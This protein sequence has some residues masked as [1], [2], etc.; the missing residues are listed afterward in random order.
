MALLSAE[1]LQK[2]SP[3]AFLALNFVRANWL[4]LLV[5]FY[6]VRAIRRRYFHP[7]SG[8]PGPFLGSITSWYSVY[9]FF[10]KNYNMHLTEVELHKKYGPVFRLKPDLLLCNDPKVLPKLFHKN[11]D[12]AAFI[13]IEIA[14]F[15]D[16][17]LTAR[18]S[19]L[20]VRLKKRIA[21]AYSMTNIRRMESDIDILVLELIKQLDTRFAT[22]GKACDFALWAQYFA[23]DVVADVAFG[24]PLGFIE[25]GSDV[26]Q[27]VENFHRSLPAAGVMVRAHWLADLLVKIPGFTYLMPKSGD[28]VGVGALMTFRDKLIKER[29]KEG[30][31]GKK[32]DLLYHFLNAK[33]ADGTPMTFKEIGDECY[34][35]LVAGSDTTAATIRYLIRNLIKPGNEAMLEKLHAELSQANL[36]R[37]VPS[38]DELVKLPYLGAAL[39]EA[40]RLNGLGMFIPRAISEPGLEVCGKFVPPGAGHAIAM[41]PWVVARSKEVYGEDAEVFNPERWLGSEEEK[42]NLLRYDFGWGYGNRT[43]LGKSIAMLEMTKVVACLLLGFDMRLMKE[44]EGVE[45]PNQLKNLSVW[46]EKGMWV[47]LKRKE[48]IE[49]MMFGQTEKVKA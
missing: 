22:T 47:E 39:Y 36:T 35:I 13:D 3:Y 31:S 25:A 37:P 1:N 2:A 18:S 4:Y 17:V 10:S 12:K 7:L 33:N 6:V 5:G 26:G 40:M 15:G 11:A 28:T 46:V 20:H 24:K 44:D 45:Y 43:C 29:I 49:S 19:A 16:S 41:T 14:G 48:G 9:V 8:F 34:L 27:L 42:R 23:Y 32:A 30:N 21:G 38:Y